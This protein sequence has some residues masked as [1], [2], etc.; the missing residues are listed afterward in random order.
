MELLLTQ[1]KPVRSNQLYNYEPLIA[2]LNQL[3]PSRDHRKDRRLVYD[4]VHD[5]KQRIKQK[6]AV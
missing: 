6:Q 2:R 5:A 4:A 3:L 1:Q